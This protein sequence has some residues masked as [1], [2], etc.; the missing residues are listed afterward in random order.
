MRPDRASLEH[1]SPATNWFRRARG[2]IIR[3]QS[4]LYEKAW[5]SLSVVQVMCNPE[6]DR[7]A[8]IVL[9]AFQKMRNV[10]HAAAHGSG[11][12][13]ACMGVAPGAGCARATI[14]GGVTR[15]F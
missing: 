9:P 6:G 15:V 8:G 3:Q 11:R 1:V 13:L 7:I 5:R 2:P 12:G 4:P 10:P 14:I